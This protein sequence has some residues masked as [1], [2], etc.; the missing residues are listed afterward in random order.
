MQKGGGGI[1]RAARSSSAVRQTPTLAATA[2]GT[3]PL[4]TT[5]P[6]PRLRNPPPLTH[7]SPIPRPRLLSTLDC[8]ILTR[9]NQPTSRIADVQFCRRNFRLRRWIHQLGFTASV[10]RHTTSTMASATKGAT[11]VWSA[12]LVRDTFLKFF[13]ERGHTFGESM[14]ESRL[15]LFFST[16]L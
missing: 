3:L 7:N 5:L 14:P 16:N 4:T 8:G 12:P 11:P 1:W 2:T 15:R 13:E 10:Q 6:T 9:P